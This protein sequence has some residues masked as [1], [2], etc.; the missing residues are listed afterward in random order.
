[1]A[2]PALFGITILE[3]T[4]IV[5]LAMAYM[6]CWLFYIQ[7]C[8]DLASL[9]KSIKNVFTCQKN[10]ILSLDLVM[11]QEKFVTAYELSHVFN[12]VANWNEFMK[13]IQYEQREERARIMLLLLLSQ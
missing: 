13:L 9:K 11:N 3:P 10:V 1:M 6:S 8:S 12:T 2:L 7:S 4:H 5:Y